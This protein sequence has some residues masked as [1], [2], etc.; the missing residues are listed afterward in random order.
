M[1]KIGILGTGSI[2]RKMAATISEMDSA[3]VY[4]ELRPEKKGARIRFARNTRLK[5]P[6][7]GMKVW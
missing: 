5:K 2:A 7:T 4:R 3:C 6:M 1:L